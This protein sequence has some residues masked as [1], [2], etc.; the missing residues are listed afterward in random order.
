[1]L[2]RTRTT[3]KLAKRIDLQYFAKP[4]PFRR[5]RLLLSLLIPATALAWF[6][7]QRATAAP[8]VYS[9]GP[10]S[11]SHAVFGARCNLCHVTEAGFFHQSVSDKACL[12]CHDA[13]AHNT[14]QVFTPSCGSCHLEHKGSLRLA[15]TSDA[16]CTQCHSSLRTKTESPHFA[17][18]IS[19]F[20]S[21]HPEFAL[22][23]TRFADP[24]TIKL[25]HYAHLQPNLQGPQSKVQMQCGDCHR[26]AG[27]EGKWPYAMAAAET[28][29]GLGDEANST[30]KSDEPPKALR[31][32]HA[33]GYMARTEYAQQCAACHVKDLQFDAR[34]KDSVPHD[35]PEIVHKYLVRTFTDYLAAHPSAI[36]EG[37]KPPLLVAARMPMPIPAPP[38]LPAEWV[39]YQVSQSE[40]L[41]WNKGCKL[42]H[43]MQASDGPLPAV[44]KSN[45]PQR[46]LKDAEFSHDAHR[47]MDCKSCHTHVESSRESSDVLI[48]TIATCRACHREK[49]A[50]V[51]AAE[52][53]C[54]ECHDYHK[55]GNEQPVKGKFTL[56]QLRATGSDSSR[57]SRTSGAV[58]Q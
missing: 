40:R 57:R 24:G 36:H 41:L 15:R 51:N 7:G 28:P 10:V 37:W 47:M 35:K 50:E 56:P 17:K 54:F 32:A 33:G 4:H 30:T 19:S 53:R 46:W 13:P 52:G 1:M 23:R 34:F 11:S 21:N 14:Q 9:S 29:H 48:P 31:A 18:N 12:T 55:W 25:N 27:R 16:A 58:G 49:G 42:C 20:D 44:A 3:K 26:T 43:T 8:K 39:A 2:R 45:I 38:H 22:W 6:V 5:W